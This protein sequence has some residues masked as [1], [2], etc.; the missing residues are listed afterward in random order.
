M[1][2]RRP[3][4]LLLV[5]LLAAGCLGSRDGW[6]RVQR[7]GVLR[8]G[9]DPTFPPFAAEQDGAL[10]G[11]DVDLARALAAEVGVSAEF[12]P[13]SF[14]GLYDALLTQR[15]DVLI[16]ALVPDS[17]RTRDFAFSAPYYNAGQVLVA[18]R[19]GG[20][21]RAAELAGRTVAVELGTLGHVEATQWQRRLPD[22]AIVTGDSAA[23]AL[24]AVGNG[25]AD[26]AIVDATSAR[27]ALRARPELA[28]V[29]AAVTVEPYVV[30]VRTEDRELLRQINRAL[31]A[32]DDSGQLAQIHARWLDTP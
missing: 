23:A 28:I 25:S 8:V 29:D 7:S 31:D 32:L 13:I 22:V 26:A 10:V 11:I 18:R 20:V 3:V 6:Q 5:V 30:V 16:A 12:V 15:V 17:T 24:A 2:G 9:L 1:I 21:R 14:D 19:D 27:L 4:V